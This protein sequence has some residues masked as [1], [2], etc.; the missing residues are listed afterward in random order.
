MALIKG[1]N[2]KEKVAFIRVHEPFTVLDALPLGGNKNK[3]GHSSR[4]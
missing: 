1:N 3:I 4:L 2:L